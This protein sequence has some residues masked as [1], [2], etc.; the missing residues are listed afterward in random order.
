MTQVIDHPTDK[1]GITAAKLLIVLTAFDLCRDYA[2]STPVNRDFAKRF[3]Q[4]GDR[5]IRQAALPI[6]AA[7]R[8]SNYVRPLPFH[9]R[10]LD[11]ANVRTLILLRLAVIQSKTRYG[12]STGRQG[13]RGGQALF[14]LRFRQRCRLSRRS[15]VSPQSSLAASHD[16]L[17][18][19]GQDAAYMAGNRLSIFCLAFSN[20]E[21]IRGSG[22]VWIFSRILDAR[23]HRDFFKP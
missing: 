14:I 3:E 5:R 20:C 21:A 17:L 18:P 15:P 9:E 16:S 22:L 11:R 1:F 4:E 2:V 7:E 12:R 6:D 13:R 8:K 19:V 10:H 23:G